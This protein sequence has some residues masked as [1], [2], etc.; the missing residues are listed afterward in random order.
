MFEKWDAYQQPVGLHYNPCDDFLAAWAVNDSSHC[1]HYNRKHQADQ[2]LD[3]QW[4]Q[5]GHDGKHLYHKVERMYENKPVK[6]AMNGE[7]TY[8]RMNEGKYGIGWWQGEDAWNQLM[9]GGTMGVVYGAATLWQWKITA[10]EQGWEPWTDAPFNW[11]DA[12]QF[13]GSR[14]V[15]AVAKAFEGFDFTD[16]EKRT[17][18][19]GGSHLLLANEGRFYVSYLP[20]GGSLRIQRFPP[21]LPHYWF[22]PVKGVFQNGGKQSDDLFTAPDNK[23]PWVF[24]AG[25]KE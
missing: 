25:E 18:L 21:G 1:F 23:N 8:E 15:G 17:D 11:Q 16:M 9:H 6:A 10:Q 4:A 24:I 2:W 14:Y 22:D 12:L 3:F 19:T 7:P 13:E 5:T 20:Q